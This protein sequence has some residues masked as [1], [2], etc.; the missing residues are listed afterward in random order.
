[1]MMVIEIII[2]ILLIKIMKNSVCASIKM[3]YDSSKLMLHKTA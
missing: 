1:M 2:I 3:H